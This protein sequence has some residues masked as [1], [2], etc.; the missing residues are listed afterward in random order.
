MCLILALFLSSLKF[1]NKVLDALGDFLFVV[2]SVLQVR[3]VF[4]SY[5]NFVKP[6]QTSKVP[7]SCL[8]G[9]NCQILQFTGVN[10]SENVK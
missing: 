8:G 3:I 2:S 1:Q 4:Y 7:S 6:N 10:L 9:K 5:H